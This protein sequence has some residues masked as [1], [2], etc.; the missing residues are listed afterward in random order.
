MKNIIKCRGS[1]GAEE[2]RR[3]QGQKGR[4]GV[5]EGKGDQGLERGVKEKE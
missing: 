1:V 5:V 4:T 2:D 3:D